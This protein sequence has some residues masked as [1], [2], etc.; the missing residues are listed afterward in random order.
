MSF[1]R[2]RTFVLFSLLVTP[3]AGCASAPKMP[4]VSSSYA[5][6][7][8]VNA[9]R[10]WIAAISQFQGLPIQNFD[11]DQKYFETTWM[12][13]FSEKRG[14]VLRPLDR[15]GEKRQ[16][17]KIFLQVWPVDAQ[18]SRVSI[19]TQAEVGV[20]KVMGGYRWERVPSNGALERE[21]IARV[22][23]PLK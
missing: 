2:I 13:G 10:A 16:R 1:P 5:A 22:K 8:P 23:K 21:L 20:R 3:V 4:E 17:M 15:T 6:K 7:I 14:N 9:D 19:R 18:T 11:P 12:E